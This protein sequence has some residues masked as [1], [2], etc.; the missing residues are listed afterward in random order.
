MGSQA[1]SRVRV[2]HNDTSSARDDNDERK[3]GV[4][5]ILGVKELMTTNHPFTFS[6]VPRPDPDPA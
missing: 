5:I 3:V 6:S 1:K 4:T 2:S